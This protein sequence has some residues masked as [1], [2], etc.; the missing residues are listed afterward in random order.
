MREALDDLAWLRRHN[1]LGGVAEIISERRRMIEQ[2]HTPGHEDAPARVVISR[3][4][5][6]IAL[7]RV[8]AMAAAEIDLPAEPGSGPQASST[9][10]QAT[11]ASGNAVTTHSHGVE[12][13]CPM[14]W[15][16]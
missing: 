11:D 10:W 2:G 12:D 15:R 4:I 7:A 3:D 14:S 1:A 16:S 9:C 13:A 5:D 6:R 8:G